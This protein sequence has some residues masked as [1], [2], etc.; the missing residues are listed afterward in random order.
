MHSEYE[1]NSFSLQ[2]E[3]RKKAALDNAVAAPFAITAALFVI[4]G[5]Y[6]VV[7]LDFSLPWVIS[8]SGF[9]TAKF[10][11]SVYLLK[12]SQTN[13]LLYLHHLLAIMQ[14]TVWGLSLFVLSPFPDIYTICYFTLILGG[15]CVG[16]MLIQLSSPISWLLFITPAMIL[17]T[18]YLLKWNESVYTLMAT[19]FTFFCLITALLSTRLRDYLVHNFTFRKSLQEKHEEIIDKNERL[20]RLAH[21]DGLTGAVNRKLLI[22]MANDYIEQQKGTQNI[23]A[24]FLIDLDHFKH[25]NDT[26]GH[27]AGDELLRIVSARL[28]NI[29]REEDIVARIGGDEFGV[30]ITELENIT[31]AKEIAGKILDTLNQPQRIRGTV[32][33]MRASIGISY[34]PNH[35]ISIT[36]LMNN[37]D[38]AL[39]A[40]KRAGRG[41]FAV[42][43]DEL[44]LDSVRKITFESELRH[45]LK[46]GMVRFQYQPIISTQTGKV[47]GAEALM[48]VLTNSSTQATAED[49]VKVSAAVGLSDEL[50]TAL[51]ETLNE[52]GP[53]LFEAL[54]DLEKISINLSPIDLRSKRPLEKL[55]QIFQ[56]GKLSPQ[57]IQIEITE[58][59]VLERGSDQAQKTIQDIADLGVSIVMDDFGTGYSSLTHLKMLPISGIKIDKSFIGELNNDARDAAIVRSIIGM[60]RGLGLTVTAEGVEKFGQ[61]ETLRRLGCDHV[62]GFLFYQADTIIGLKT[63]L[64]E[65]R[66]SK[67]GI[68][69][70]LLPH[71][72]IS[73]DI[74]L[75]EDK[76]QNTAS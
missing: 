24:F 45:A 59:S 29:L 31:V 47:T 52:D 21:F 74:P 26:L 75:F 10:V 12:K 50:T 54:P 15:V 42:C 4:A 73:P 22:S 14:G 62:Q 1:T 38:L 6:G 20:Y 61:F 32:L 25:L 17:N 71:K 13:F 39:Q 58:Q 34:F 30:F 28:K 16:S 9:A 36:E 37:A 19:A 3:L 40:A 55:R 51:L 18:V 27:A 68:L 76:S 35:G 57:Q 48:R 23:C 41:V 11:L 64:E 33:N 8:I 5:V 65:P 53:A 70:N 2:E 69:K 46:H 44:Q 66:H 7:P 72:A 43:S 60:C 49:Y 63:A 56:E 67:F